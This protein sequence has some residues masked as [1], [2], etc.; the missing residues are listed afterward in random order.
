MTEDSKINLFRYVCIW[1]GV[2]CQEE[3]AALLLLI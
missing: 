2:L 1:E 3:A